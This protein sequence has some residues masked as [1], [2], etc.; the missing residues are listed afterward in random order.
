MRLNALELRE[1]GVLIRKVRKE[2]GLRL[3]DLA[4]DHIS[5]ATISNIER[6][7]VSVKKEKVRYLMGKLGLSEEQL[8]ELKNG[9]QKELENIELK[10][11]AVENLID[12]GEVESPSKEFKPLQLDDDHPLA[13]YYY[14]L[15]G[16]LLSKKRSWEK[17]ER[18]L[19]HAISLCG[20]KDP[21]NIKS[22]CYNTLSLCSYN[23]SNL[24]QA[25]ERADKGLECFNPS[26]DRKHVKYLLMRNKAIYLERMGLTIQALRIVEEVW[27]D[28]PKID[29]IET[30]LGLYWLRAE[31]LRKNRVFDEAVMFAKEGID[32]A[33]KNRNHDSLF[34][35]WTVL[36]SIYMDQKEWENA[37][38]CFKV[39]LALQN[40]LSVKNNVVTTFTRLGV[41]YANQGKHEEAKSLLDEAVETGRKLEDIPRL[42]SALLSAGDYY[43]IQKMDREALTL[44]QELVSLA[45][46]H[47]LKKWEYQGWFRI[48]Q[49]WENVNEQEFQKATRNMFRVQFELH[50]QEKGG[51]HL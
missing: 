51:T 35:L 6:G 30:V 29:Q 39:A 15:K 31:L 45:Q 38:S 50:T 3:E 17:A 4:D 41:L 33:R 36:G 37:E 5:P 21:G 1:I 42:I 34:D 25:V 27:P 32:I 12:T 14:F 49:C 26:G 2:R 10:L 44:Y 48:A 46:K 18:A 24:E 8:A 7:I 13:S 40:K 43:R 19:S 23:Q 47:N 16:K 9:E 20:D 11:V 28:I 22:S